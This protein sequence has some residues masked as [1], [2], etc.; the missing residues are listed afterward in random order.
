MQALNLI[1]YRLLININFL[2]NQINLI[3]IYDRLNY[4]DLVEKR[5]L[6][7]I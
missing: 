6:F 4:K 5:T 1:N 3:K 2:V 7:Q